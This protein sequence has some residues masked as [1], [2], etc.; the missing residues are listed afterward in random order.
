M[1]VYD[2]LLVLSF[3]GPEKPEDVMPFLENV[4]RGR[5]VPRERLL[6]V[7][8]N[9]ALF[10][11][12]SPINDQT[13][14]LVA[15]LRPLLDIPVYWGNRNWHPFLPDTLR[16]MRT[17]GIRR[18]AVFAT[19]AYSS[20]SACR[21]YLDDLDSARLAAGV[22]APECDKLRPFFDH[23]GFIEPLTENLRAAVSG[24]DHPH[25]V[26]TA[27]SIPVEMAQGAQYVEQLTHVA[28]TVAGGNGISD[29]RLAYQS[30]S[31]PPHQPWLEPDVNVALAEIA[32]AGGSR[33][34]T[35]A[36]IGFLSDHLEILFDLDTQ[37]RATAERLGLSMTRA[38]TPITHPRFVRMIPALLA[39]RI[40][41][42]SAANPCDKLCCPSPL[43]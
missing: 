1:L 8:K 43:R 12:R 3:G 19:S 40:A 17:D 37:A 36:P 32:A 28:R 24:L 31:G 16:Q 10:G 21:Q 4:T 14:A 9:Y 34:V 29:W 27:H 2:A 41:L 15:A 42:G 20:F 7:E 26:F 33:D 5:R 23:P 25:V 38:A 39:E 11:G 13:R 30:R 18:A 6:E 22:G 35:I